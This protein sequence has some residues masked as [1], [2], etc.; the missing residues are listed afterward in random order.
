[1]AL[2]KHRKWKSSPLR[3]PFS[4]RTT[5]SQ[6][7]LLSPF[8]H[9]PNSPPVIRQG[10]GHNL[11]KLRLWIPSVPDISRRPIWT[12]GQLLAFRQIVQLVSESTRRHQGDSERQY[13]PVVPSPRRFII[14]ELK[15]KAP[16]RQIRVILNCFLII[17]ISSHQQGR[18]VTHRDSADLLVTLLTAKTLSR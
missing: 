1:M 15:L 10:L 7:K 16:S 14:H 12:A 17:A 18:K 2:I 6:R 5:T 13:C 9:Y 4:R 11:Q 3:N 8:P